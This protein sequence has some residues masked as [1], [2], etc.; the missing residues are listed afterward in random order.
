MTAARRE[1]TGQDATACPLS[2]LLDVE[3]RQ[4]AAGRLNAAVLQSQRQEK[5]PWLPD[6]LRQLVHTQVRGVQVV[7]GAFSVTFHLQSQCWSTFRL[8]VAGAE[9]AAAAAA[10]A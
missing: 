8:M 7:L 3:Q 5:G 1:H 10:V 9:A 6:L 4:A 2:S